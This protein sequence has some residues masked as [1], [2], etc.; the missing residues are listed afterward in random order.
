MSFILQCKVC[1][2]TNS[3]S[4]GYHITVPTDHCPVLSGGLL[5]LRERKGG[6]NQ[7][8]SEK[9][10]MGGCCSASHEA[11][12]DRTPVYYY[13]CIPYSFVLMF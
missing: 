1:N 9:Q 7:K 12:A 11:N 5:I 13:V 2:I 8:K 4:L 6:R 10:K 3:D